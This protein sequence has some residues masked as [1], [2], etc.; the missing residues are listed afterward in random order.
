[1]L[2]R[3]SLEY[4]IKQ[5][6]EK[7]GLKYWRK[8]L[9]DNK[10]KEFMDLLNSTK[11]LKS[12]NFVI[13][14]NSID[15]PQ[16]I[17]RIVFSSEGITNIYEMGLILGKLN[18][19]YKNTLLEED[20]GRNLD[21]ITIELT[22][23]HNIINNVIIH[24]NEDFFVDDNN[25]ETELYYSSY[26]V[27]KL[28][29]SLFRCDETNTE[30]SILQKDR[31]NDCL[32][33]LN[34][35][36]YGCLASKPMKLYIEVNKHLLNEGYRICS[37]NISVDKSVL[38]EWQIKCS[39]NFPIGCKE[40]HFEKQVKF[41][42]KLDKNIST[43]RINF[44]PIKTAHIEYMEQLKIDF[45][46]LIYTCGEIVGLWF[47]LSPNQISNLILI[48]FHYFKLFVNYLFRVH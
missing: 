44:I 30:F 22:R 38:T 11:F 48:E 18:Q 29:N 46:Q 10:L 20:I 36:T 17:Y 2:K 16:I 12:C 27:H 40:T 39:K 6:I 31:I 13:K 23:F 3:I 34:N 26:S 32:L 24:L 37:T 1:M 42:R 7:L 9:E 21:K 5:E 35:Q 45:N 41:Y 4:R 43:K 25:F 14:G 28:S 47:G 33:F 19:S 8:L 15:C